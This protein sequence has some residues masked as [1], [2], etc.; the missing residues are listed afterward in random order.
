[1]SVPFSSTFLPGPTTRGEQDWGGAAPLAARI[2]AALSQWSQRRADR[3]EAALDEFADLVAEVTESRAVDEALI[4]LARQLAGPRV[5]EVTVVRCD[6]NRFWTVADPSEEEQQAKSHVVAFQLRFGGRMSGMLRVVLDGPHRLSI[7]RHRRL[8]TL[9]VLAA[10]AIA[11]DP[12][13]SRED[14]R[15]PTPDSKPHPTHDLETGLPNA[16]FLASFLSYALALSERRREPLSLLYIGVDRL[17]AIRDVHGAEF[18]DEALRKV[19]RTISGTLRTSDL[20]ARLPDGRLVAVLP[21]ASVNDALMVAEAVRAAVAATGCLS[22]TVSDLTAS[23]GVASYPENAGD[24][25]ALQSVAA[26][27]LADARSKGR[28]HVVIATPARSEEPAPLLRIT[29]HQD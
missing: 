14:S 12:A 11:R 26:A 23:I 27:A 19:G 28:D 22:I 20:L 2:G 6:A 29:H 1:M 4:P 3:P 8:T 10:G 17:G 5:L 24:P 21:G 13:A 16:V 9:A 25:I 18:A 7:E 15:L